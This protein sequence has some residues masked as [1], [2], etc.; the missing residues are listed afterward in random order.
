VAY[1]PC[2]GLN[3]LLQGASK[4]QLSKEFVLKIGL[5]RNESQLLRPAGIRIFRG[6]ICFNINSLIIEWL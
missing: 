1:R 3:F 2:D 4:N 6:N 5:M